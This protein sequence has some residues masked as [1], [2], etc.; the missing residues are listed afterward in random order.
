MS[1]PWASGLEDDMPPGGPISSVAR[2]GKRLAA[3][4][5]VG[6]LARTTGNVEFAAATAVV[7]DAAMQCVAR[8][9]AQVGGLG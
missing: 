8:V 7:L 9:T 1:T 2:R 4:D 5:R 3:L 6:D